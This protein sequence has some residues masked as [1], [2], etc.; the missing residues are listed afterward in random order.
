MNKAYGVSLE[1]IGVKLALGEPLNIDGCKPTGFFAYA[2]IYSNEDGTFNGIEISDSLSPYTLKQLI[3][4]KNGDPVN[5]FTKLTDRVGIMLLQF[6]TYE[7]MRK[8]ID[9]FQSYY[10]INLLK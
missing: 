5:R 4:K 2:L 10:K 7:E 1:E 3:F 6:P 9:N 8:I